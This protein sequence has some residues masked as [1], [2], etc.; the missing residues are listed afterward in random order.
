MKIFL[1]SH[2]SGK[3]PLRVVRTRL[4]ELGYEVVSRWLDYIG[5]EGVEKDMINGARQDLMDL[6]RAEV[7]VVENFDYIAG[8]GERWVE[9]G[10]ILKASRVLEKLDA[11]SKPLLVVVG[12]RTNAFTYLPQVLLYPSWPSFLKEF[13]KKHPP[14]TT[15]DPVDSWNENGGEVTS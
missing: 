15:P 1:S 9:F 3:G 7:L 6:E 5:V 10:V 4:Q 14:T 11:P 2:Y 8:R 12:E 13:P